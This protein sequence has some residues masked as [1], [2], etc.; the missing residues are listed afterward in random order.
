VDGVFERLPVVDVAGVD[1]VDGILKSSRLT[2]M[3]SST[4]TNTLTVSS[5]RIPVDTLGES[6]LG[7]V[8]Y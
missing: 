1:G 2:F 8:P 4:L 3:A 7:D 6:T 5:T